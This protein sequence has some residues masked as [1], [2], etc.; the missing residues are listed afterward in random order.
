[1]REVKEQRALMLIIGRGCECTFITQ[2]IFIIPCVE[3]EKHQRTLIH[4][5]T[6]SKKAEYM[7]VM[8][9][10]GAYARRKSVK[11]G[12]GLSGIHFQLLTVAGMFAESIPLKLFKEDVAHN[13]RLALLYLFEVLLFPMSATFNVI[14]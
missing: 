2:I 8:G 14:L 5:I 6:K 12:G 4:C 1:M 13:E 3:S 10:F 11:Y 7:Q 9:V